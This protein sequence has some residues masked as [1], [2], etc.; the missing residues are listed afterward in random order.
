MSYSCDVIK[1]LSNL[2]TRDCGV[3]IPVSDGIKVIKIN[4]EVREL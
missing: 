3:F 1:I 4:Q 2:I